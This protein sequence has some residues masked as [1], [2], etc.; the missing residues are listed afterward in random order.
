[1]YVARRL[2]NLPT[3]ALWQG[4]T[5]QPEALEGEEN[6]AENPRNSDKDAIKGS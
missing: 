5:P 1:M 6:Y 4:Q 2:G 3:R